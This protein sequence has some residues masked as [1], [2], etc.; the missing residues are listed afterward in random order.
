[1]VPQS[2]FGKEFQ[3]GLFFKNL[4]NDRDLAAY[5]ATVN[6]TR[7]SIYEA[8]TTY[9]G[10]WAI[11]EFSAR[12]GPWQLQ[13]SLCIGKVAEIVS[14]NVSLQGLENATE[15]L[16]SRGSPT[17]NR[18]NTTDVQRQLA[19]DG[20]QAREPLTNLERNIWTLLEFDSVQANEFTHKL[21]QRTL[22]ASS[23]NSTSWFVLDFVTAE[24]FASTE[25]VV[26]LGSIVG[27]ISA[28][29]TLQQR[30]ERYRKPCIGHRGVSNGHALY[31]LLPQT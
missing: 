17:A 21:P 26:Q 10:E 18:V 9:D 4:D 31:R 14:V 30:D 29:S 23:L 11:G 12:P 5:L 27:A 20:S 24:M 3:A 13:Y 22:F 7:G 15:P 19:V 16:L 8:R 2:C 28:R 1:M 25:T 6:N